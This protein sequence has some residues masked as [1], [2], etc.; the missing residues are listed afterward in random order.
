MIQLVCEQEYKS[1]MRVFADRGYYWRDDTEVKV[2]TDKFIYRPQYLVVR[3]NVVTYMNEEYF[4][5]NYSNYN[6]LSVG[7]LWENMFKRQN[8]ATSL[9]FIKADDKIQCRGVLRKM[10]D[11]GYVWDINNN[12]I[13]PESYAPL[14]TPQIFVIR[15]GCVSTMDMKTFT[16]KY[17]GR[18]PLRAVE[19]LKHS[20]ATEAI[21]AIVDEQNQQ[22]QQEER[23][24]FIWT[25]TQ[26]IVKNDEVVGEKLLTESPRLS[27]RD[28][29]DLLRADVYR[30]FPKVPAEHLNIYYTRPTKCSK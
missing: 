30:E 16:T 9:I 10:R 4:Y 25:A 8:A 12:I 21:K 28:N 13:Q 6:P 23:T 22:T 5:S 17:N 11:N 19:Y 24:M 27:T 3:G 20:E 29:S 15:D 7:E 26:D 14:Y 2:G 1:A 18:V